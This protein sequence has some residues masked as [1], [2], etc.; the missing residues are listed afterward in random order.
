VRYHAQIAE[1]REF[2]KLVVDSKQSVETSYTMENPAV[3]TYY[4]RVSSV[5]EDGFE[6]EWSAV[7][8][9]GVVRLQAPVL[10]K[11]EASDKKLHLAW[12][13]V[14]DGTDYQIQVAGD[15]GFRT[16]IL[17][18]KL[19]QTAVTIDKPEESGSYYMRVRGIDSK[20]HAGNYSNVGRFEVEESKR[21]PYELLSVFGLFFLFLL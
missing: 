10:D 12:N 20:Q 16:I 14:D 8:E 7:R 19:Q 18:K 15:E 3:G 13:K 5:E 2:T 11:T 9:F 21:F 4:L 1:D 6:G 17:D